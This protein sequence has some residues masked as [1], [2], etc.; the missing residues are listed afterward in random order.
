MERQIQSPCPLRTPL[1]RLTRSRRPQRTAA[2]RVNG[3]KT[4]QIVKL[5]CVTAVVIAFLSG[6]FVLASHY[7]KTRACSCDPRPLVSAAGVAAEALVGEKEV[8]KKEEEVQDNT[9]DAGDDPV[10]GDE[11]TPTQA[12]VD[13]LVEEVVEAE[14]QLEEEMKEVVDEEEEALQDIL[15]AQADHMKKIRL[16]IDLIMGNPNLAGREVNCEVERRQVPIAP[17]I[18]S[19]TILVTCKDDDDQNKAVPLSNGTPNR[20]FPA[21]RPPMSLIAPLMKMLTS[22]PGPQPRLVPV[23]L[24]GP[25]PFISQ[26]KSVLEFPVRSPFSMPMQKTRVSP[27]VGISPMSASGPVVMAR[28]NPEGPTDRMLPRHL[29]PIVRITPRFLSQARDDSG[30]INLVGLQRGALPLPQALPRA[31]P[32]PVSL[33]PFPPRSVL[34]SFLPF[35]VLGDTP[36]GPARPRPATHMEMN[37]AEEEKDF[38]PPRGHTLMQDGRQIIP[39]HPNSP[40]RPP[41]RLI[42]LPKAIRVHSLP[43]DSQMNSPVNPQPSF[44]ASPIRFAPEGRRAPLPPN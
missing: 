2:G 38:G 30:K 10:L 37:A 34:P 9:L 8:E 19:Q 12:Q 36:S 43:R 17:G 5:V 7:M 23:S 41:P 42:T 24:R 21:P 15:K 20:P 6:F 44:E 13:A 3:G 18:M 11:Q 1:P 33:S 22:R 4:V 31:P 39:P 14:Q 32:R 25:M 40:I 26:G 29:Q 28:A 16:P 27:V 35:K